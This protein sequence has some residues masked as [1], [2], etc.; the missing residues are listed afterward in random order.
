M[1]IPD[2]ATLYNPEK[3]AAGFLQSEDILK[4]INAMIEAEEKRSAKDN[5]GSDNKT[6]LQLA[7]V[8]PELKR[9]VLQSRNDIQ[10]L[11]V[12]NMPSLIIESYCPDVAPAD[13]E[14]HPMVRLL[15]N[16]R[17]GVINNMANARRRG[18]VE[19]P[20]DSSFSTEEFIRIADKMQDAVDRND[21]YT[22]DAAVSKMSDEDSLSGLQFNPASL[23]GY[24]RSGSDTMDGKYTRV[25]DDDWETL[26]VLEHWYFYSL[27]AIQNR[28]SVL[29]GDDAEQNK[30]L[31]TL[32]DDVRA[33]CT[34]LSDVYKDPENGDVRSLVND[35]TAT[36]S[37]SQVNGVDIAA[38]GELSKNA[39]PGE[40]LA[41]LALATPDACTKI[42]NR[43]GGNPEAYAEA[44]SKLKSAVKECKRSIPINSWNKSALAKSI[45]RNYSTDSSN[46][47]ARELNQVAAL[48]TYKACGDALRQVSYEIGEKRPNENS[49][50]TANYISGSNKKYL[51]LAPVIG[52]VLDNPVLIDAF[53]HPGSNNEAEQET[54]QNTPAD[55]AYD[56][57]SAMINA[58]D[59]YDMLKDTSRE[60]SLVE[61]ADGADVKG[62]YPVPVMQV[63]L[64]SKE[65]AGPDSTIAEEKDI[66]F[67][68]TVIYTAAILSIE[69]PQFGLDKLGIE[70]TSTAG[71]TPD[72]PA[73][74]TIDSKLSNL[75]DGKRTVMSLKRDIEQYFTDLADTDTPQN[76]VSIRNKWVAAIYDK[77]I[78]A[79]TIDFVSSYISEVCD[80]NVA[81]GDRQYSSLSDKATETAIEIRKHAMRNIFNIKMNSR[82]NIKL[83]GMTINGASPLNPVNMESGKNR[84]RL[85]GGIEGSVTDIGRGIVDFAHGT[86]KAVRQTKTGTVYDVSMH[87]IGK[88]IDATVEESER[89]SWVPAGMVEGVDSDTGSTQYCL[90]VGLN[91]CTLQTMEGSENTFKYP[92]DEIA[93]ANAASLDTGSNPYTMSNLGPMRATEKYGDEPSDIS[94]RLQ[95]IDASSLDAM[96]GIDRV[97]DGKHDFDAIIGLIEF[98]YRCAY[99]LRRTK[100]TQTDQIALLNETTKTKDFVYPAQGGQDPYQLAINTMKA[101][102]LDFIAT[103]RKVNIGNVVTSIDAVLTACAA[104]NT[105][106]A[107]GI[108]ELGRLVGELLAPV[109]GTASFITVEDNGNQAYVQ[110][111]AGR[112]VRYDV[113]LNTIF[114]FGT[115]EFGRRAVIPGTLPTYAMPDSGVQAQDDIMSGIVALKDVQIDLA[116]NRNNASK[117][118][119]TTLRNRT[120]KVLS[121]IENAA[122]RLVVDSALAKFNKDTSVA[123]NAMNQL[124]ML[125]T[126]DARDS[127]E[128]LVDSIAPEL[129]KSPTL[130]NSPLYRIIRSIGLTSGIISSLHD[131]RMGRDPDTYNAAYGSGDVHTVTGEEA[132]PYIGVDDTGARDDLSGSTLSDT[133]DTKALDE[134]DGE[135]ADYSKVTDRPALGLVRG[136]TKG[137]PSTFGR[138]SADAGLNPVEFERMVAALDSAHEE[139]M[140]HRPEVA[141]VREMAR[142]NY[143]NRR[144]RMAEVAIDVFYPFMAS[145]KPI[146]DRNLDSE[147]QVTMANFNKEVAACNDLS[148]SGML[149]SIAKKLDAANADIKSMEQPANDRMAFLVYQTEKARRYSTAFANAVLSLENYAKV[150]AN[151][152]NVSTLNKFSGEGGALGDY[153]G[154]RSM[155][156]PGALGKDSANSIGRSLSDTTEA[157]NKQFAQATVE[158]VTGN[159]AMSRMLAS[160]YQGTG[161]DWTIGYKGSISPFDDLREKIKTKCDNLYRNIYLG[162]A[163]NQL[164]SVLVMAIIADEAS[165]E[166]GYRN[167]E[168]LVDCLEGGDDGTQRPYNVMSTI[169][170]GLELDSD[171]KLM[172]PTLVTVTF[173]PEHGNAVPVSKGGQLPSLPTYADIIRSAGLHFGGQV[174]SDDIEDLAAYIR[175][176]VMAVKSE[177]IKKVSDKAADVVGS[178]MSLSTKTK[179]CGDEFVPFAVIYAFSDIDLINAGNQG[180]IERAAKGMVGKQNQELSERIMRDTFGDVPETPS[181]DVSDSIA[182]NRDLLVRDIATAIGIFSNPGDLDHDEMT[183][184][185]LDSLCDNEPDSSIRS[186]MGDDTSAKEFLSDVMGKLGEMYPDGIASIPD[187]ERLDAAD[188]AISTYSITVHDAINA[189]VDTLVR[190]MFGDTNSAAGIDE[191]TGI[192][193]AKTPE[194]AARLVNEL[195]RHFGIPRNDP[196]FDPARYASNRFSRSKV[197]NAAYRMVLRASEE[198]GDINTLLLSKYRDQPML[199]VQERRAMK[200]TAPIKDIAHIGKDTGFGAA[201]NKVETLLNQGDGEP[202]DKEAIDRTLDDAKFKS[203]IRDFDDNVELVE[204]C[205]NELKVATRK[206]IQAQAVLND[207]ASSDKRK[208]KAR[209]ALANLHCGN[210]GMS[211]DN[212]GPARKRLIMKLTNT[213]TAIADQVGRKDEIGK[214]ELVSVLNR[215]GPGGT[216]LKEFIEYLLDNRLYWTADYPND[217][218]MELA[219]NISD[220]E[221]T[222][223]DNSSIR[224][225]LAKLYAWSPRSYDQYAPAALN[226]ASLSRGVDS[227]QRVTLGELKRILNDV[228]GMR[229]SPIRKVD[230]DVSGDGVDYAIGDTP[231][232]ES[233]ALAI[234]N[235]AVNEYLD[236]YAGED[237]DPLKSDDMFS[238]EFFQAIAHN[239]SLEKNYSLNTDGIV[240]IVLGTLLKRRQVKPG[241]APG[242]IQYR[243]NVKVAEG[244]VRQLIFEVPVSDLRDTV[245]DILSSMQVAEDANTWKAFSEEFDRYTAGAIRRRDAAMSETFRNKLGE[246]LDKVV[247]KMSSMCANALN[248][249]EKAEPGTKRRIADSSTPVEIGDG[250]TARGARPAENAGNPGFMPNVDDTITGSGD[251]FGDVAGTV[252]PAGRGRDLSGELGRAVEERA[253]EESTDSTEEEDE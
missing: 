17:A 2:N 90:W 245:T 26:K 192:L 229:G 97:T 47:A 236:A 29:S 110:D 139:M 46:V 158:K 208:E 130:M 23:F 244:N 1:F 237:S 67:Q 61:P 81:N 252:R 118:L 164:A 251:W 62:T 11:G 226:A 220:Q 144:V 93:A 22:V 153:A 106:P 69:N 120:V 218:L 30:K 77:D 107:D 174:P 200:G 15:S 231:L 152:G 13:I 121:D 140:K 33:L 103:N 41:F 199:D 167:L 189:I 250:I 239:A 143:M 172:Q 240:R 131:E 230:S 101:I 117:E 137:S 38:D 171:K 20:G 80:Y 188:R 28:D 78:S 225:A 14:Q 127:L 206:G 57:T 35:V 111:K 161:R 169:F 7:F 142:T 197:R 73:E 9:F 71:A 212:A 134:F 147:A 160:V 205:I 223:M 96:R 8:H 235:D 102:V 194:T 233:E 56:K 59:D 40:I 234:I 12:A 119:Y 60:L 185:A 74:I 193:G 34:A 114:T 25:S 175:T 100:K 211:T 98:V 184:V 79:K 129:K 177:K 63:P 219:A 181:A 157:A 146:S 133:I 213:M 32:S 125:E 215:L 24:V 246:I 94:T 4:R 108:D 43:V 163:G 159:E 217:Q 173:D 198:K 45:E 70:V 31:D 122:Y 165:D 92:E 55:T 87:V 178:V 5:S 148:M 18:N 113:A 132:E 99:L 68:G 84:L 247:K 207:A 21:R 126:K 54:E 49:G 141:D 124:R 222:E 183:D 65:I 248:A 58:V 51:S 190:I 50:T 209:A 10:S 224:K 85:S 196:D 179:G 228:S 155:P 115:D 89:D 210:A 216:D 243:R 202:E 39:H 166:P 241:S 88:N 66:L 136:S 82:N 52:R 201:A 6:V 221:I 214:P 186:I 104:E 151:T 116:A 76:T 170:T 176:A 86:V 182:R 3:I 156:N 42:L 64:F 128:E 83:G 44:L 227:E 203:S 253:A 37:S 135:R 149:S 27:Y 195:D 36:F 249:A 72:E 53:N 242:T 168:Y 191:I 150:E 16:F 238:D 145:A 19:D 232:S 112:R 48:D 187:E 204:N 75:K 123:M 91:F 154:V 180:D 95:T 138:M 109:S 162:E 105:S